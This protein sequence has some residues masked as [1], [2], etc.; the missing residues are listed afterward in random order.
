MQLV[1]VADSV[2]LGGVAEVVSSTPTVG[3]KNIIYS[4]LSLS[5]T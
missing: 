2:V 5:Q 4:R 3:H 1:E